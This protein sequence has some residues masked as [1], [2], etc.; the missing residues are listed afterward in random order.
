MTSPRP[1]IVPPRPRVVEPQVVCLAQR[2]D[3]KAQDALARRCQRVAYL[4][5]L[6]LTGN[7][8]EALDVSQD[9]MLRFFAA[10]GR[11]DAT[12]PVRPWLLR[13]VRNLVRDRFRRHRVRRTE[14]LTA[15]DDGPTI[16]P[17]ASTED[18]E[19]AAVQHQLRV[20]VWQA[21]QE[22]SEQH[23]EVL[24]LRDYQDLSY[25]E[26]AATLGVPKGTV[27]SRLH[28]ARLQVRRAVASRLSAGKEVADD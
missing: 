28:R 2:G 12:R 20:V 25:V 15:V 10:L 18:P 23:R 11:F 6:Q 9:A 24:V 14:S 1:V 26:I 5:A 22:L 7:P 19:A 27:M 13:I 3:R 4:F 21:V 8:D 16:E 17:I